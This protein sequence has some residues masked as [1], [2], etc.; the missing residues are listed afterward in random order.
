VIQG[1]EVA[2][3]LLFGAN[4]HPALLVEAEMRIR[5]LARSLAVGALVVGLAG[6]GAAS[7]QAGANPKS[8]KQAYSNK[9]FDKIYRTWIKNDVKVDVDNKINSRVSGNRYTEISP[10]ASVR[11]GPLQSYNF[12]PVVVGR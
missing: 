6:V 5:K 12:D 9:S 10:S 4:N 11:F 8:G 7:A 2:G 3:V 1:A